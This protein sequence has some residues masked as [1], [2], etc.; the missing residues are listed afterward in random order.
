MVIK[1]FKRNYTS[2]YNTDSENYVENFVELW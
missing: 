1:V 2:L